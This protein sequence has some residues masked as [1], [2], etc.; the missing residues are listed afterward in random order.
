MAL[1]A[2]GFKRVVVRCPFHP[3]KVKGP[4]MAEQQN[5][6]FTSHKLNWLDC[7]AND[8][9]LKHAAFKVAYAIMQHVNSETLVAW[10]SDDT[11]VDVTGISRAQVQRHRESLKEAGW[12]AWERTGNANHYTPF[13]DQMPAGLDDIL[14]KRAKRKELRETRRRGVGGAPDASP[15]MQLDA[16]PVRQQDASPAR[17]IHLESNTYD[18]TPNTIPDLRSGDP[19]AEEADASR[20]VDDR[21]RKVETSTD[22]GKPLSRDHQ[23]KAPYRQSA[24]AA[25]HAMFELQEMPFGTE[26]CGGLD[27]WGADFNGMSDRSERGVQFH[28]KRLLCSGCSADDIVTLA[29]LFLRQT[30][31]HRRPSLGG[32]L[33]RFESYLEGATA[34][35]HHHARA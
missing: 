32:F 21:Y 34:A 19:S 29:E 27:D 10:L 2:A 22:T 18:S 17:H 16:S 30:P 25:K 26:W 20:A 35:D 12:L 11:L 4:T 24:E 33:A 3:S 23:P 1:L 14:A 31:S 15:A 28:W 13:F 6:S 5:K 8:R 9:R 7:V